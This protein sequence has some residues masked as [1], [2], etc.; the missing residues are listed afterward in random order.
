MEKNQ[1]CGMFN[2]EYVGNP[3]YMLKHTKVEDKDDRQM[4]LLDY[5]EGDS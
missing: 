5:T 3:V 1:A 4:S 2:K